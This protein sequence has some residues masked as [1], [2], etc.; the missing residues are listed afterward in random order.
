MKKTV[1]VFGSALPVEEEEEFVTA[2]RLGSL[3]GKN[4]FNVCTGGYK[5]IME[6]VSKGV[7]ENGGDVTGVTL[8]YNK[9]SANEYVIKEIKSENLFERIKFLIETADAYIFLQ[10]GTGTLLEF[11]AVWEFMNKSLIPVK[12]IACHSLMWR[13]IG[14]IINKQLDKEKNKRGYIRYFSKVEDI[15][16]YLKKELYGGT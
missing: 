7:S 6:A 16:E 1:T 5:G 12:P 11:A 4:N 10:G 15:A 8:N 2:Y 3:L 14:S 13:E 9:S